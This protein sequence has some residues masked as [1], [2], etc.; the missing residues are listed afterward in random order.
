MGKITE[1]DI[2]ELLT[3]PS[4]STW[5]SLEYAE[6]VETA[7]AYGL[8]FIGIKYKP[9]EEWTLSQTEKSARGMRLK[10]FRD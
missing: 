7:P 10:S 5:N 4:M 2:Y 9:E 3:I 1:R 6:K 8:Y